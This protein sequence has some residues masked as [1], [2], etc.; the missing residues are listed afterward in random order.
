MRCQK[1][2]LIRKALRVDEVWQC[3]VEEMGFIV[4]YGVSDGG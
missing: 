4:N 1:K 3:V 2:S